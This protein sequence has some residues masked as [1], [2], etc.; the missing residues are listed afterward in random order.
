MGGCLTRANTAMTLGCRRLERIAASRRMDSSLAVELGPATISVPSNQLGLTS[1]AA[2]LES[3]AS[4]VAAR[5]ENGSALNTFTA[6]CVP[7]HCP[8][9][10]VAKPP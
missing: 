2:M 7:R 1:L 9:W 8:E 4:S 6:T 10:T 5:L 3:V